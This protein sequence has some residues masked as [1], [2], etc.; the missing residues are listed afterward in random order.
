MSK[1]KSYTI[2]QLS[3]TTGLSI[4]TLRYYDEQGLLIPKRNQQNGYRVYEHNHLQLLQFILVYRELDFSLE[5]IKQII[6][7]KN[8]DLRKALSEQKILLLNQKNKVEGQ[9]EKI[10]LTL[11]QV[12]Q[13]REN[14]GMFFESFPKDKV[15]RWN[16]MIDQQDSEFNNEL[17]LHALGQL[18][19][20]KAQ[21]IQK[22][23]DK[24]H[25]RY[26]KLINM[27]ID[28]E[29]VQQEIRNHYLVLNYS[30]YL[31]FEGFI[32]ISMNGYKI[33]AEQT[34]LNTVTAEMLEHYAIGMA[35]HLCEAMHHFA[36]HEL[37]HN[38]TELRASGKEENS[39]YLIDC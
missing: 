4:R 34:L 3:Q 11:N 26:A 18:D 39:L 35:Q 8:F 31:T 20:T 19:K 22:I 32:G 29:Q 13:G 6:Y 10:N 23:S 37:R 12:E 16:K 27:P 5:T 38:E 17:G 1:G 15:E 2:N 28:S 7:A 24:L 14:M 21:Q 25:Q 36:N 30:L 33:F 9:L